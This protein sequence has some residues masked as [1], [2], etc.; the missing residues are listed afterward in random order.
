MII[1]FTTEFGLDRDFEL[2]LIQWMKLKAISIG[3]II[4][5]RFARN[6]M[7]EMLSRHGSGRVYRSKTGRGSHQASAPGEPPAPDTRKYLESWDSEVVALPD[8]GVAVQVGTP[9]WS[10]F[11][12]RLE[13]GGRDKRGIYIAPRPHVRPVF[14]NAENEIARD[15]QRLGE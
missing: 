11:G 1:N 9:L 15:L 3:S 8:G 13:L 4:Q 7:R 14:E 6:R 2:S 12:R 5:R 10:V